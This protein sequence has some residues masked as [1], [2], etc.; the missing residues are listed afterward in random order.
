MFLIEFELVGFSGLSVIDACEL[1]V[2]R[3]LLSAGRVTHEQSVLPN[4][5]VCTCKVGENRTVHSGEPPHASR[6]AGPRLELQVP[7]LGP[8]LGSLPPGGRR[9]TFRR[10]CGCLR[11]PCMHTWDSLF[12]PFCTE[13]HSSRGRRGVALDSRV[14]RTEAARHPQPSRRA[15]SQARVPQT[16]P[17]GRA[18]TAVCVGAPRPPW[19]PRCGAVAAGGPCAP[20]RVHAGLARGC[21][22]RSARCLA[23]CVSAL[24][25]TC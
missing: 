5:G 11:R 20:R 9:G 4:S 16:L 25:H 18:A 24:V 19:P 17:R 23:Y 21:P 12:S 1:F 3:G 22:R 7:A 8:R 6:A 14:L 10:V 13:P 15:A 2:Q